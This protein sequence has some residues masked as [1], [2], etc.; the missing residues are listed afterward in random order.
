MPLF[1][2]KKSRR[3]LHAQTNSERRATARRRLKI[4]FLALII[5]LPPLLLV[6]LCWGSWKLFERNYFKGGNGLF[7]I[8]DAHRDVNIVSGRISPQDIRGMFDI[9]DGSNLFDADIERKRDI[10]LSAPNIKSVRI[11]R[12]LP[13]KMSILV[14]ERTPAVRLS[15]SERTLVADTEGVAF[16]CDD[17]DVATLPLLALSEEYARIEDG[18][19]ISGLDRHAIDL[20]TLAQ[21]M[22]GA[23]RI[24][25]VAVKA[26]DRLKVTFANGCSANVAWAGMEEA[27][28]DA[29]AEKALRMQLKNLFSSMNSEPGKGVQYWDATR[30]GRISALPGPTR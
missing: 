28:L 19:R 8:Q 22:S 7:V 1:R 18:R 5:I 4:A 3:T 6:T 10:L 14:S 26:R 30:P 24:R 29:E 13:N 11:E 23:P 9:H 17:R 2:R 12:K 20:I 25:E 16:R 15:K 21:E 27:T